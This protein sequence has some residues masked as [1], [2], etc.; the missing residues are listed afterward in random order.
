MER[1]RVWAPKAK[2][3]EL[4]AGEELNA[5]KSEEGGLCELVELSLSLASRSLIRDSKAATC[6]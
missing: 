3:V 4:Q 6:S 1:V 2:V 5:M